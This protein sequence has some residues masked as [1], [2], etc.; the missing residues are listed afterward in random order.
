[1][2]LKTVTVLALGLLVRQT[3]RNAPSIFASPCQ[4]ELKR[5]LR[6]RDRPTDTVHSRA[7][8]ASHDASFDPDGERQVTSRD[9]LWFRNGGWADGADF[10]RDSG[11]QSKIYAESN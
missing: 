10:S 8:H 4:S 11:H 2:I 1:M 5:T 6:R 3:R 7:F 9:D